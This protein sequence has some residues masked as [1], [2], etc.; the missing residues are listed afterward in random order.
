[1]SVSTGATRSLPTRP[2]TGSRPASGSTWTR[3]RRRR[4][5]RRPWAGAPDL[6]ATLVGLGM[7]AVIALAIL[8][9]SVGALR[10]P[11]GW[12]TALGQL[13][14][15]VGTY[16]LLV[17]L[18][19]IARIPAVER[20][21]GQD[22]L[23]RWH[24]RLGAWPICL[25]VAHAVLVT[26]GY[27]QSARTGSLHQFG[28]FLRS[29]P[30]V[31]AATVGLALIVLAGVLSFRAA[32]RRMRYET[33]WVVHLYTYL[34]IAL[35]FAHQLANG[36]SF[37]GHPLSRL[38]WAAVWVAT[39]G[40]VLW[41]RVLVPV[42]RSLFHGLRVVEVRDEAPGVVSIVLA[43][44]HLERLAVSGGQFF[45]WRFLTRELWWQAHPYSLSALP[46]PP[47]LRVTVKALG[48]HGQMLH[49]IRIGTRVAVEG[50]Y[51]AFTRHALRGRRA[52]LVAAGVGV[53]P[54]RALLEDLPAH[55]STD[56][57]VRAS[58]SGELLF[59]TEID[60]LVAKRGGRVHEL[61]GSRRQFPT[62]A[63]L[64]HS[65]VPDFFDRDLY[66]CGPEGFTEQL[67]S[68]VRQFGFPEERIHY[69]SFAF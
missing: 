10:A 42:A 37:V 4:V 26:V 29:Y 44:R 13:F 24:R 18:L 14:G 43:G 67:V 36:Q 54:L 22:R 63:V 51:G 17:M 58:S 59:R 55:V 2:S 32:R 53:T 21:V 9:T 49:R 52:L 68:S 60:R 66:I 64:L 19:L 69:E 35:S 20:V 47:Y 15:L 48:D 16:L 11:G 25:L 30:D 5:P 40:V 12:A 23:V 3:T 31:L 62:D 27:A 6:A 65:I 61:V 57:V 38:L 46:Q 50:P 45:Q 39:A 8:S 56:V 7:G 41:F 34:A 28:I 1:M 33:W